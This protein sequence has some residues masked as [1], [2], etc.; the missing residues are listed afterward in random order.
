MSFLEMRASKGVEAEQEQVRR[1]MLRR[2]V[3]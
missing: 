3:V 2:K 1:T